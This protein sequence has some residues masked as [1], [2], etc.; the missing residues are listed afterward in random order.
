M[1]KRRQL[2]VL[3]GRLDL[4]EAR[5]HQA[6]L[7]GHGQSIEDGSFQ[8]LFGAGHQVRPAGERRA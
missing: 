2:F 4:A 5:R 3:K 1:Q 7:A 8:E 6:G